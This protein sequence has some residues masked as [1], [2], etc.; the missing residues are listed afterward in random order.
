MPVVRL[1]WLAS[2][3]NHNQ[4]LQTRLSFYDEHSRLA[5][6][7]LLS[8]SDNWPC[9]AG[10]A[11]KRL[12][13]HCTMS[14]IGSKHHD[15]TVIGAGWTGLL[16]CKY[17]KE[18][19][20]SVVALEKREDIGGIW[21]YSDDPNII[22][23]MKTT[24]STSSS[25]F[26]EMSD[27][28]MPEEIGQFP[29]HADIHRYLHAYA[30]HFNLMP[31]IQLNTAVQEAERK[32]DMWCLQCENGDEYTSSYLVVATGVHEKPNRELENTVLKEFTG[33]MYHAA[34]IKGATE[35]QRGER[36][37]IVGGGETGS[38]LCIEFYDFCQFIYWSIPRGQHF[39]RKVGKFVKW[40]KRKALDKASSPMLRLLLPYTRSKPGLSW[41]CKWTTNGSLLAYQGHGI[42]EWR[43]NAKFFHYIINKSGRVLDLV[44]YKKVVPKA[45]ITKCSGCKVYFNDGTEQEFDTIIMS[46]GY[47]T[48]FSFLPKRYTDTTMREHYKFVFDVEDPTL[49]FVGFVRPVVGSIIT[50]AETQARW[51]ARVF[52]E[53]VPLVSL[54]ER[55]TEVAR[56]RAFWGHY[57]KDSSQRIEGSV[58][59]FVYTENVAKLAGFY[60]DYWALFKRNPYHWY[61]ACFSPFNC[62]MYRLNEPKYEDQAIATMESHQKT[63]FHP[64]Y[65]VLMFFLRIVLFDWIL[66]QLQ[67]VKYRIQVSGWWRVV[68]EWRIT[69]AAN[70]VWTLPKRALFGVNDY[71]DVI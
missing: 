49:A 38:D 56:D 27:Y 35:E 52:S 29:H 61:V 70:W 65:L 4:D 9:G 50:I 58:E 6:I 57:F 62:S 32:G 41:I 39:F 5:H 37:L 54:K 44:D 46:T 47:K 21:L 31:H 11:A 16:A 66:E 45:G 1:G 3:A 69:R 18:E 7:D 59:Q 42:P 17:M 30:D 24:R 14:A 10:P 13:L 20:L 33:K 2:L 53:K 25:T 55:Q 43:N 64:L 22:T 40:G 34:E 36:L 12:I 28:P 71:S 51:V 23:V 67:K 8:P 19:G 48:S 60:P 68:R 15:V 26:T 63:A